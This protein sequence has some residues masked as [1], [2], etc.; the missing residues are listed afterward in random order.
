MSWGTESF[1]Y[2]DGFVVDGDNLGVVL[3]DDI[4]KHIYIFFVLCAHHN[5]CTKSWVMYVKSTNDGISW[6]PPV[7]ITA[8]AGPNDFAPGPGYGIQVRS[9][10]AWQGGA[11]APGGTGGGLWNTGTV[12]MHFHSQR[13][14]CVSGIRAVGA[15]VPPILKRG[16][17][18]L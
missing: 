1:I 13:D 3:V 14:I 2:N 9:T 16:D 12:Q 11:R 7:N 8:Q 18:N 6:L 4:T 5:Q 17:G 15:G 10:V